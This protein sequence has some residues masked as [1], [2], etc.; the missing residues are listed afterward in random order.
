MARGRSKDAMGQLAD[1]KAKSL[2]GPR[3]HV[4]IVELGREVF[5]YTRGVM[6]SYENYAA[7]LDGREK[8]DDAMMEVRP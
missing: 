1:A 5:R 3:D 4:S 6:V 2:R 8:R 7:I